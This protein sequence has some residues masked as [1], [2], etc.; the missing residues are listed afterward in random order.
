M[1]Y[2]EKSGRDLVYEA[3]S[4]RS[5]IYPTRKKEYTHPVGGGIYEQMLLQ[6]RLGGGGGPASSAL[7][8]GRE[9]LA[10]QLGKD[11]LFREESRGKSQALC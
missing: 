11:T 8:L 4:M 2:E 10:G 3:M 6:E 1:T 5:G 7:L 9:E